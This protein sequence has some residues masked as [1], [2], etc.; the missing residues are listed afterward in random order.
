ME[1]P[2]H[3]FGIRWLRLLFGREFGLPDMMIIWDAIFAESLSFDLVD[4]IFVA[5]IMCIREKLLNSDYTQCLSYLMKY[6]G[7]AFLTRI[8]Q[9]ALH[10]KYPMQ[11]AKPCVPQLSQHNSAPRKAVREQQK[12]VSSRSQGGEAF[13]RPRTLALPGQ[14]A[15]AF[16]ANSEPASLDSGSE[17]SDDE[18]SLKGDQAR[19]AHSA[20]RRPGYGTWS[21]QSLK[22]NTITRSLNHIVNNEDLPSAEREMVLLKEKCSVLSPAAVTTENQKA[23]L[24]ERHLQKRVYMFHMTMKDCWKQMSTQLGVLQE[25]MCSQNLQREDEMLLALAS[26][27]RVRD[28]LKEAAELSDMEEEEASASVDIDCMDDWTLVPPPQLAG[29]ETDTQD[30]DVMQGGTLSPSQQRQGCSQDV[31]Y[32][33]E[34]KKKLLVALVS[35]Q[36]EQSENKGFDVEDVRWFSHSCKHISNDAVEI[37]YRL[38]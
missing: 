15:Q 25:C 3:I 13:A 32:A 24:E 29:G 12:P 4:F 20:T 14:M 33:E 5:M 16:R 27:K 31:S 7:G 22:S 6:P 34:A 19:L 26:L 28:T 9:L 38:P 36:K 11:Y 23:S 18:K 8:I 21:L 35:S 17:V 10:L 2:L 1:I 37:C 30:T